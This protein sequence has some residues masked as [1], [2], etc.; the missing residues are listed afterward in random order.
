MLTNNLEPHD[1]A[2]L[3]LAIAAERKAS[4]ADMAAMEQRGSSWDDLAQ[5]A[6][7]RCQDR[8]LRLRPWECAPAFTTDDD[9][10][11]DVWGHRPHEIALLKRM[12][13]AGIS[14]YHPDPIKA[15]AE[16]EADA[17]SPA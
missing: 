10:P 12:L 6:V 11:S 16:A 5:F 2:A 4:P 3:E 13:A 8:N 1:R 14:R 15:I 17:K 9:E 7:G